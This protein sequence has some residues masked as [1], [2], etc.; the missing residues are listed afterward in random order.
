M[1]EDEYAI[2]VKNMR[3][4][5]GKGYVLQNINFFCK[6]GEILGVVGVSGAGK[7]TLL[8]VLLGMLPFEGEVRVGGR[9]VKRAEDL[10][11]AIGYVP[12]LEERNLYY[13]FSAIDNILTF[14]SM[15]GIPRDRALEKAKH[16]LS[17]LGI[18]RDVWNSKTAR[19]SGGE[20]KR[21]S[22]AIGLIHEPHILFLDEPTT[23]VDAARRFEII[24]YLKKLNV[25]E[26]T[27]MVAV[28]HDLEMSTIMDR[29]VILMKGTVVDFDTP[30]NLIS[31]L[32][33][34]GISLKLR[35]ANLSSRLMELL[36][37]VKSVKYVL[38]LG[39]DVIEIFSDNIDENAPEIVAFLL[40]QGAS[41]SEI[42]KET[43]SFASYFYIKN[44]IYGTS[45]EEGIIIS[46]AQTQ[47]E[48]S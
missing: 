10:R 45:K 19:L 26:G 35:I 15:Y 41:I 44:K 9:P 31:K 34:N 43:T 23:G 11:R 4:G 13:Q 29:V 25:T 5:Y 39:N 6:K 12:Q 2:E 16:Y 46:R 1:P 7:T 21:L 17:L 22:I 30:D 3:V 18:P 40:D 28:T 20:K 14:A 27:T 32:P 38:R 42:K 36:T 8:R 47:S 48:V 37:E 33:S 24:N